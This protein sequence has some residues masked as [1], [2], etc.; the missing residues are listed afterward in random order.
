MNKN[1][2]TL[3]EALKHQPAG[4]YMF[5]SSFMEVAETAIYKQEG[6]IEERFELVKKLDEAYGMKVDYSTR[7]PEE[8]VNEYRD[9]IKDLFE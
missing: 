8:W 5:D 9:D 6:T 3:Q 2:M 1:T 7:S 4:M